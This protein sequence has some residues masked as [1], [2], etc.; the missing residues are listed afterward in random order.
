MPFG[1]ILV[2]RS[3]A[4]ELLFASDNTSDILFPGFRN[5]S[6]TLPSLN[7]NIDIPSAANR[8]VT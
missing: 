5:L 6:E 1:E 4:I 2:L 3:D 8:M 7:T